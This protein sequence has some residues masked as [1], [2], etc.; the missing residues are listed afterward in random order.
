MLRAAAARGDEFDLAIIDMQMP[1]MDGLALARAIQT[2]PTL[3]SLRLVLITSVGRRG[4]AKAAQEV[5]IAGYLTKPI[6]RSQ[7][8][9]CLELVMQTTVKQTGQATCCAPPLITRHHLA[10]RTTR[11]RSRI[12]VAEDNAVN[13]LVIVQLLE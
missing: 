2:N 9:D 3:Q 6:R 10:E 1:G 5:G 8:R 12:L 13:Q 4:D 7:L 11:R